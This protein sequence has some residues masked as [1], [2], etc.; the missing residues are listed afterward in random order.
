VAY[1][2]G[3]YCLPYV[4]LLLRPQTVKTHLTRWH[5][6]G[7]PARGSGTASTSFS[8]IRKCAHPSRLKATSAGPPSNRAWRASNRPARPT[9][10]IPAC[11]LAPHTRPRAHL[12]REVRPRPC[13]ASLWRTPGWFRAWADWP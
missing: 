12:G 8:H 9:P 5:L 2:G 13:A 1:K 10:P 4:R 7:E 6:P 3:I 11:E